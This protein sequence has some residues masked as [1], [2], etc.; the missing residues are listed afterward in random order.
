MVVGIDFSDGAGAAAVEARR[1]AG[2]LGLEPVLVHVVEPGLRAPTPEEVRSWLSGHGLGSCAVE[3]T[4]GVPWI[5]L[6]RMAMETASKLLV[7]GSHGRTGFQPIRPGGTAMR[8]AMRS[9]IPVLVVPSGRP[10][11][12]TTMLE[13]GERDPE[14]FRRLG[15]SWSTRLESQK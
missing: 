6:G 15:G 9:P 8:L 4:K 14:G 13:L 7:V 1:L 11:G 3:L 5:E 10:M 2:R 12:P